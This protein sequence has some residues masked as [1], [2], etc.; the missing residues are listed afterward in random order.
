VYPSNARGEAFKYVIF[1][2][3]ELFDMIDNYFYNFPLKTLKQNR[4]NLI[5]EFYTVRLYDN[6]KDVKK[7]NE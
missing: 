2:K 3:K 1:R 5:K 6:D 4:V 7:L